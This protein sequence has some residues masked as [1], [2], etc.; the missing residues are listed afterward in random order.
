MLEGATKGARMR[1]FWKLFLAN[2]LVFA[3]GTAMLAFLPVT[4]SAPVAATEAVVLVL[5]LGVLLAVN[6]L[7]IHL[8]LGPLE[9]VKSRM[10]DVDLLRPGEVLPVPERGE[11]GDVVRA[12]NAMLRRLEEERSSSSAR[13]LTAQENERRRIARELHDEIGQSLTA[14]L[15]GLRRVADTAPPDVAAGLSGVQEM[16]RSCLDEVR[17][18]ARRLR[19]G[20][21]ED[22]GLR[23]AIASLA[24]EFAASTDLTVRRRLADLRTGD[25]QVDLVVYRVAQEALTNIARH[26]GA[27]AVEIA[28]TEQAGGIELSVLDDGRGVGA[29]VESAGIRGMRERA[30]LVG[31]RLS[32]GPGPDG[33]TLVRL[34]VPLP[35]AEV[36]APTA[37]TA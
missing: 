28:L 4:V 32:V 25:D 2:G 5:G 36:P 21:L 1:L 20:V 7:L 30:L 26:A 22:L 11:I 18:V 3:L 8:T 19:P 37:A 6:G 34:T 13:A 29:A 14:V 12:F 16:T 35:A 31:G 15:L 23:S 27:G 10:L 9:R 33:G 17:E 24:T